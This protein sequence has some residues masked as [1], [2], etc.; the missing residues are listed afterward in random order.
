[1]TKKAYLYDWVFTFNPYT[2]KYQ[3]VKR[4]N[5]TDLFSK[6]SNRLHANTMDKLEEKIKKLL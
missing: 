5:F 4:D 3:A 2:E 6:N 1:M